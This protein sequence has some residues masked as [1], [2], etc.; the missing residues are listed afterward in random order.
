MKRVSIE[1]HEKMPILEIQKSEQFP[2]KQ[3]ES[4]LTS[5]HGL[6]SSKNS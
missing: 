2:I 3:L 1:W 4:V 6:H 5:W